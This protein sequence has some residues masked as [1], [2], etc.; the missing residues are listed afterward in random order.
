[1]IVGMESFVNA[2]IDL[3]PVLT[4]DE[5]K[6]PYQALHAIHT[7]LRKLI[8]RDHITLL[9]P[10]FDSLIEAL[11]QCSI[12]F[13]EDVNFASVSCGYATQRF[14]SVPYEQD[15]VGLVFNYGTEVKAST[16]TTRNGF[17]EVLFSITLCDPE[18]TH[19]VKDCD[20]NIARCVFV[21][22]VRAKLIHYN[23][24]DKVRWVHLFVTN[25]DDGNNI[26][27]T[28][29]LMQYI[30]VI[31]DIWPDAT[32]QPFPTSSSNT[33]SENI[34]KS[35]YKSMSDLKLIEPSQV[36][37]DTSCSIDSDSCSALFN[38]SMSIGMTALEQ[39]SVNVNWLFDEFLTTL[40][41]EHYSFVP[42]VDNVNAIV[43]SGKRPI[44]PFKSGFALLFKHTAVRLSIMSILRST[45]DMLKRKHAKSQMDYLQYLERLVQDASKNRKQ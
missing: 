31:M 44:I 13:I 11:K 5:I 45:D 15:R 14:E 38:V 30:Q 42:F 33:K 10:R 17:P 24:F 32:I 35:M 2:P 29:D 36:V 41:D 12:G 18:C 27:L 3:D 39:K 9:N 40:N 34:T 19:P 22:Q 43:T 16:F 1:M 6:D 7:A 23:V 37:A 20:P 28:K 25:S 26:T 21:G 4:T 8:M